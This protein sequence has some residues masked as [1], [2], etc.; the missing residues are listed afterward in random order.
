MSQGVR[1]KFRAGLN[2]VLLAACLLGATGCATTGTK[3]PV[4]KIDTSDDQQATREIS[5]FLKE[6][7]YT[8]GQSSDEW[9]TM[10][11]SETTYIFQPKCLEQ[12]LDRLVV[13]IYWGVKD[14]YKGTEDV[15]NLVAR[16][17]ADMNIGQFSLDEDNDLVYIS[18]LTYTDRLEL[19]EVQQYLDWSQTSLLGL[20]ISAPELL[21]Y[22]E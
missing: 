17:N 7:G 1:M 14:E 12:G 19:E 20:V 2:R 4:L 16:L 15:K 13:R 6:N 10:S 21:E 18:S 22:L 9:F 3:G 11:V 5:N 8:L